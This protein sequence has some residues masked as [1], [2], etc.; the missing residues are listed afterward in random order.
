MKKLFIVAVMFSSFVTQAQLF[1]YDANGLE[2]KEVCI[3]IEGATMN[4]ISEGV[5]EFL[6]SRY[7]KPEEV[8]KNYKKTP[9]REEFL[10]QWNTGVRYLEMGVFER[11]GNMCV[12]VV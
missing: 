3:K 1:S 4:R 10:M 9:D 7:S 6:K 8:L 11:K 2:P 5:I 12:T